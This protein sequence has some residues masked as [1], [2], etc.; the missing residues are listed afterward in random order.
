MNLKRGGRGNYQNALYIYIPIILLIFRMIQFIGAT[1]KRGAMTAGNGGQEDGG[2][3]ATQSLNMALSILSLHLTQADV[4][5]AD[6][7]KMQEHVS[8]LQVL[9]C[10]SDIR[11]SRSVDEA[12]MAEF[13][14]SL[15]L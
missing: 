4:S 9:S 3:M 6:W 10:H 1:L 5:V 15:S 2:V 12:K 11:I 8:D 13:I 7:E 14:I